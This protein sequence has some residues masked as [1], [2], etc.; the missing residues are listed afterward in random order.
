MLYT[1]SPHGFLCVC[2]YVYVRVFLSM[3]RK[4]GGRERKGGKRKG[5]DEGERK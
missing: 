1:I 4:E 2:V 3:R 5:E